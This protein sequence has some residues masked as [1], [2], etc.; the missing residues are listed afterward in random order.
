MMNNAYIVVI[1]AGSTKIKTAVYDSGGH[2]VVSSD[3]R[4]PREIQNP[5]LSDAQEYYNA[6]LECLKSTADMLGDR[7]SAVEAIAM[8]GQMAGAVGVDK[9]WNAVTLWS[10]TMHTDHIPYFQRLPEEYH[11][12]L[13]PVCGT[14]A[15]FMLPKIQWM[16]DAFEGCK[17]AEKFL[18]MGNYVAGRMA[19]LDIGDAFIDRTLLEWTG[20]ADLKNDCWS[21]YLCSLAE[22]DMDKLPRIVPSSTVIGRLS[23]KAAQSI[24]LA[25]GIP[26]VA[27]AGDKPAGCIGAGVVR[28]GQLIDESST[29][30]A[31]SQCL[32]VFVPDTKHRMLETI[33]SP[34]PGEYYS[35]VYFA[36]SGAA[37]E[38]FM[39]GICGLAADKD[40]FEDLST[41][42]AALP[43]GSEGLLGIGMLSG[44]ALP[45]D[46]DVR[47]LWMGHSW[48]HSAPHFYRS[49]LESFGYEFACAW[50]VM[51]ETYPHLRADEV[52]AIGG[53]ARSGLFNQI[54]ADILGLPYAPLVRDDLTMLGASIIGGYAV[55]IYGDIRQTAERYAHAQER[56]EPN[57]KNHAVYKEYA[58]LYES[59]YDTL[60]PLYEKLAQ[61]RNKT[62]I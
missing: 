52:L 33:P 57:A 22:M 23:R 16:Y 4:S 53:G 26:I 43:P 49:L 46:P 59:A 50:N 29:V 48:N 10:G 60:R 8:T 2:H 38:W 61:L 17:K 40:A 7:R 31:L 28:P 54:K 6:V 44:R 12:N 21:P 32:D 56:F 19:D 62:M 9:D 34:I 58:G 45:L 5:G 24:G 18:I 15:P 39:T 3:I 41:K 1:D 51:R 47:G 27:G 36:G 13:L 35:M 14:N 37:L 30:G 25:E 11:R 20:C 42:A 55:G